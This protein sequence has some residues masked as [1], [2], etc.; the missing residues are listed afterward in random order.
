[1]ACKFNFTDEIL[2]WLNRPSII[3]VYISIVW[4]ARWPHQLLVS[5][6]FITLFL[7]QHHFCYRLNSNNPVLDYHTLT[8]YLKWYVGYLR[9]IFLC[10]SNCKLIHCS[11]RWYYTLN[12][13]RLLYLSTCIAMSIEIKGLMS[14]SSPSLTFIFRTMQI[15]DT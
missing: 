4:F 12:N 5:G 7:Y 8:L 10:R 13:Q 15:L 9:K 14:L 2:S 11:W 6:Y 3:R 1:M